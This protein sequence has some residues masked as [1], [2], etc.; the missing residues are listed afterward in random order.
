MTINPED[1]D[2]MMEPRP[3]KLWGAPAIARVLGVSEDTVRK[4]A[5]ED[6]VPIY[7]PRP[8]TYFARREELEA[9]LRT[10]AA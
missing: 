3:R 7:S 8:R 10:K 2:T 5:R 1:F 9:W 4:W 6:G